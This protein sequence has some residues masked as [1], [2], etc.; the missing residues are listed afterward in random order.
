MVNKDRNFFQYNSGDPV[1][2]ILPLTSQLRTLSRKVAIKYIGSFVVYNIIDPHNYI[3]MTLDSKL[4][5]GL[6]KH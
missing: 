6:F 4:L 5:R 1:Y 2:T 3:L